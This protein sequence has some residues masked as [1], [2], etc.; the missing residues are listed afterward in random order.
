MS[1]D[2]GKVTAGHLRRDAYLYVRQSTMYQVIHN[3]ESTRRQYDL[4]GRAIALGWQSSQVARHRRRPGLL[5]RVGRG[6]GR[7]PAAGRRGVAGPAGIVLGLECSRLARDSADWQQLIKICA[8]NGTLICDEDG[9]YDPADLNDR[10]L[11]A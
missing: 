9:L 7:V 4:K 5:R 6:P 3:T 1:S 10:L 11:L 8:L 2:S